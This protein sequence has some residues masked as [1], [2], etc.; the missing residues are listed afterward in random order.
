MAANLGKEK[1][2]DRIVNEIAASFQDWSNENEAYM[3]AR[4]QLS[5]LIQHK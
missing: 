5:D 1:D 4:K 3:L 2:V